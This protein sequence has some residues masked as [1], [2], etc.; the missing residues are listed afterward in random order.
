MLFK[1]LN[2]VLLG[3]FSSLW[4]EQFYRTSPEI[5]TYRDLIKLSN[6]SIWNECQ[7]KWTARPQCEKVTLNT[8]LWMTFPTMNYTDINCML[9]FFMA[10]LHSVERI[11]QMWCSSVM[12]HRI[13]NVRNTQWWMCVFG[14]RLHPVSYK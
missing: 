11:M 4:S 1:A 2:T 12:H 8:C 13:A 7:Y 10:D 9:L 6:F 3:S 14:L 5:H